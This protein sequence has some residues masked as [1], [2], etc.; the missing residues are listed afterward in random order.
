MASVGSLCHRSRHRGTEQRTEAEVCLLVSS[1]HRAA[2]ARRTR[3]WS[4]RG[5]PFGRAAKDGACARRADRGPVW[6]SEPALYCPSPEMPSHAPCA[7]PGLPSSSWFCGCLRTG[8]LGFFSQRKTLLCIF[9]CHG[10]QHTQAS[11]EMRGSESSVHVSLSSLALC[12][13]PLLSNFFFIAFCCCFFN[14]C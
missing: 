9:R 3:K 12:L 7:L 1:T 5:Q 6:L 11:P 8:G 13:S 14:F 10:T 4:S 2:C